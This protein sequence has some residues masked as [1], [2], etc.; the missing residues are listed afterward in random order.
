VNLILCDLCGNQKDCFQKEIDGREFDIC[1]DCWRPLEE[2]LRGKGRS[3]RKRETVFR[4]CCKN[5]LGGLINHFPVYRWSAFQSEGFPDELNLVALN[6]SPRSNGRVIAGRKW[7]NCAR[8]FRAFDHYAKILE[9][10]AAGI[11]SGEINRS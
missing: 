4:L 2:K 8:G 7:T 5:D 3:R 6:R 11:K 1:A 10:A 9:T